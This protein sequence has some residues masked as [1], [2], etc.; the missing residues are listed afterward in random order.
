VPPRTDPNSE[1]AV[2]AHY[3]GRIFGPRFA[4]PAEPKPERPARTP[5]KRRARSWSLLKVAKAC[6]AVPVVWLALLDLAAARNVGVVTPTRDELAHLTGIKRRKTISTAL[7][8]LESAGWIERVHVPVTV[9][10]RRAATLLRIMLRRKGRVAPST[11]RNHVRG[12]RRP[13]GKG[14]VAPLDSL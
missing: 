3:E 8:V 13:K 1:A 10:G 4:V 9:G 6:S 2:R 11:A 7:S 5:R 12:A 14:R